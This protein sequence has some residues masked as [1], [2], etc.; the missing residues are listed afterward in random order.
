M[1]RY[2]HLK[3]RLGVVPVAIAATLANGANL[4]KSYKNILSTSQF[5]EAC[6]LL[7]LNAWSA[8]PAAEKITVEILHSDTNV[9]ADF[10]APS[11]THSQIF[12]PTAQGGGGEILPARV[13]AFHFKP[14]QF[15]DYVR[16]RVTVT[17]TA[18][19]ET[20][21]YT[22][23]LLLGAARVEPVTQPVA[24]TVLVTPS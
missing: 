19:T 7:Y 2:P 24:A 3:E 12:G 23:I 9:S 4:T 6:L 16:F 11:P 5:E 10:T 21:T 13:L 20:M 14:G 1:L 15:K 8:T 22:A 18:G 17:T